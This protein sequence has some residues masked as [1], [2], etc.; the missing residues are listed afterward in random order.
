MYYVGVVFRD[1]PEPPNEKVHPYFRV[2][3]G[4]VIATQPLLLAPMIR[5]NFSPISFYD[6]DSLTFF[7][8][9]CIALGLFLP[10]IS[11]F[12]T[13]RASSNKRY[14]TSPLN[15]ATW[16]LFAVSWTLCLTFGSCEVT[17][18]RVGEYYRSPKMRDYVSWTQYVRL[19]GA[20][21]SDEAWLMALISMLFF[22]TSCYGCICSPRIPMP[23]YWCSWTI[24][25]YLGVSSLIAG[26]VAPIVRF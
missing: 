6:T 19:A 21:L 20:T 10:L 22:L 1:E 25:A 15:S 17:G 4:G 26:I 8:D 24:V 14:S 12:W 5:K 16:L 13:P 7:A 11:G 2:L 9:V 23:K 18:C 3:V